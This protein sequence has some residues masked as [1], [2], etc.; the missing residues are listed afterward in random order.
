MLN[1][2]TM[3]TKIVLNLGSISNAQ[4]LIDADHYTT[5]MTGNTH[6]TA[7]DTVAQVATV[8][9]AV[10]NL[11]TAI[12]EPTS[13]TKTDDIAIARDALDRALRKLA[14]KVE[15]LANDPSTP[16]ANR[17]NIVHSAGMS[18]KNQV[19]PQKHIFTA[20][21]TDISGTVLLTAQGGAKA[22]EWQ[23]TTDIINFTGRVPVAST[24]K[25][26][27]EIPNLKKGTEY[28]FFHKAIVAGT[29]TDW[30]APVILMVT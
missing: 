11:R 21:N 30:E 27:T 24:T 29:N 15:D 14:N 19:H 28:A 10:T 3:K 12:N 7:T 13:D 23:Y 4:V 18:V 5:D 22:N 9:T 1:K 16:D 25:A 20:S 26:H 2:K 17:V 8:K 6:F